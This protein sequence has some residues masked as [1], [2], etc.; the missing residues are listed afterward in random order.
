MPGGSKSLHVYLKD[1]AA[2]QVGRL[3]VTTI[4]EDAETEALSYIRKVDAKHTLHV[5][6]ADG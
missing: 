1:V 5:G 6:A 2:D 3:W 4:N